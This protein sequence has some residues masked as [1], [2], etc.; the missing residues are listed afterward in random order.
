MAQ[1]RKMLLVDD[2]D[3]S[4]YQ[5]QTLLEFAGEK[6]VTRTCEKTITNIEDNLF[7]LVINA[8]SLGDYSLETITEKYPHTPIILVD[9]NKNHPLIQQQHDWRVIGSL[10][11]PLKYPDMMALIRKC[12]S[13]KPED[14]PSQT[15]NSGNTE[16]LFK[17]LVGKTPE[18]TKVRENI[19][20]LTDSDVNVLITGESGSGKEMVAKNIHYLSKRSNNKFVAVNCGAIPSELLES[21]LF[22]HEK[23]AFTGAMTKRLGRFEVAQ[24]GTLFLD[25]IGDMPLPMQVKLLRVLEDR[26]YERVGSNTP[27]KADVRVIAATHCNLRKAIL[28]GRFREDLYYRLNVFPIEIPPLRARKEDIPLIVQNLLQTLEARHKKK[29]RLSSTALKALNDYDWPGNIRELSNLLERLTVEFSNQLIDAAEISQKLKQQ[30]RITPS[31][32]PEAR[33]PEGDFDLKELLSN[34]EANY[35]KLALEESDGT[36]SR[37]AQRLGLGRTTLVEKMRKYQIDRDDISE[38]DS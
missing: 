17:K 32:I 5:L 35:I 13:F 25:E 20:Q 22:G 12:E 18:I 26:T 1:P 6:V 21:E 28:E 10:A 2:N 19:L 23:G 8:N 16:V 33:L 36:V 3:E 14:L 31:R 38:T 34:L 29:I 9:S 37:A 30:G 24:G 7:A 15:I 27:I 4:R 11:L